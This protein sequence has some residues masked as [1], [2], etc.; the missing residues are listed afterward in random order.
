MWTNFYY[1]MC[2]LKSN[3]KAF[4]LSLNNLINEAKL[5]KHGLYHAVNKAKV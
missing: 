4:N 5:D 3:L 1:I 2:L